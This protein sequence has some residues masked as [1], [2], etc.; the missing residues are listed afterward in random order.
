MP[1]VGPVRRGCLGLLA[2]AD[3]E[4]HG[5]TGQRESVGTAKPQF[6]VIGAVGT[7][8]LVDAV[9]E[10]LMIRAMATSAFVGF[11]VPRLSRRRGS[12]RRRARPLG[13]LRHAHTRDGRP[14]LQSGPGPVLVNALVLVVVG[15]CR[16]VLGFDDEG[17]PGGSCLGNGWGW[18]CQRFDSFSP[19]PYFSHR[20]SGH[21]LPSLLI[22]R[23]R[24]LRILGFVVVVVVTFDQFSTF[25]AT[26]FSNYLTPSMPRYLA[27]R[28]FSLLVLVNQREPV[29]NRSRIGR[30]LVAIF[31]RGRSRSI[32]AN[33][34][35]SL[36]KTSRSLQRTRARPSVPW[37][38]GSMT[39][40][41]P[42]PTKRSTTLA[43]A[44]RDTLVPSQRSVR[45]PAH[46]PARYS[47]WIANRWRTQVA[48]ELR[49]CSLASRRS[50]TDRPSLFSASPS[51]RHRSSCR[52]PRLRGRHGRG[53]S[54]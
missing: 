9:N 6:E 41:K 26:R 21:W 52:V 20:G 46:S 14:L 25:G 36:T 11:M 24:R 54:S 51:L 8:V 13:Q 15:E 50:R 27:N 4:E 30:E 34:Y 48:V 10:G 31:C 39:P 16:T 3:D 19:T 37:R 33:L 45:V 42:L 44:F 23:E 40:S 2:Q 29:V 32:D 43:I 1:P 35:W 7:A 53:A 28:L 22:E 17:S 18:F 5:N 49:L 38:K 12:G 47:P